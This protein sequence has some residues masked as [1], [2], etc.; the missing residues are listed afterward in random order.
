M[1]EPK[2]KTY[3]SK[4]VPLNGDQRDGPK[5][6]IK[7]LPEKP[8]RIDFD[9][10]RAATWADSTVVLGKGEGEPEGEPVNAT[11]VLLKTGVLRADVPE[12]TG[13]TEY[14]L[15]DPNPRASFPPT[16]PAGRPPPSYE[17]GRRRKT[18]RSRRSR[19]KS[20]ARKSRRSRK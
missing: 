9:D 15:I 18:R 16:R 1:E 4:L 13:T 12:K 17:G 8:N 2:L 19:R 3:L 10:G 14:T 20:R 5:I 11:I 6:T 7:T